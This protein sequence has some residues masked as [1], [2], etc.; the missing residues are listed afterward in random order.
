MSRYRICRLPVPF[1][2]SVH[3]CHKWVCMYISHCRPLMLPFSEDGPGYH[4][5]IGLKIHLH[6]MYCAAVRFYCHMYGSQPVYPQSSPLSLCRIHHTKA[7]IQN[8]YAQS[9]SFGHSYRYMPQKS[10]V[11]YRWYPQ[12]MSL[13]SPCCMHHRYNLSG[14]LHHLLQTS[15]IPLPYPSHKMYCFHL[16]HKVWICNCHLLYTPQSL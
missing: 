15:S 1:C 8:R 3:A 4:T 11:L 12:E 7:H 14:F 10:S 2:I 13:L 6:K 5:H 16:H 9:A